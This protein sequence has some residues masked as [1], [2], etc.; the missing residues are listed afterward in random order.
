MLAAVQGQVWQPLGD[1][2]TTP[3]APL[4]IKPTSAA[5]GSEV[6]RAQISANKEIQTVGLWSGSSLFVTKKLLLGLARLALKVS[7]NAM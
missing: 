4:Q 7:Q 1:L 2:P 5:E 6:I 3:L